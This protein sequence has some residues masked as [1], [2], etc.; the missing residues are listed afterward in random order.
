MEEV[1]GYDLPAEGGKIFECARQWLISEPPTDRIKLLRGEAGPASTNLHYQRLTSGVWP[2]GDI[3]SGL[4]RAK[5]HRDRVCQ[6]E[7]Q[8]QRI[9]RETN[10]VDVLKRSGPFGSL[11]GGGNTLALASE[12][13]AFI[14]AVRSTLDYLTKSVCANFKNESNSF[15]E[16]P[17]TIRKLKPAGAAERIGKVLGPHHSALD[18]FFFANETMSVRDRIAH[19][20]FVRAGIPNASSSG[21]L[22]YGGGENLDGQERLCSVLDRH[23]ERATRAVESILSELI[24]LDTG[25]PPDSGKDRATPSQ[26]ENVARWLSKV[27][28]RRGRQC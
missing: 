18:H 4:I 16:W 9:A 23:V 12:Y 10:V 3:H 7:G 25:S 27:W 5:Y 6:M 26:R 20:E 8:L 24:E 28:A 14:L 15:H 22:L 11:L 21:V 1:L 2:Y 13:Q 17:K 19:R